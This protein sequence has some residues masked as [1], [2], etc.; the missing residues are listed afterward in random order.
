MASRAGCSSPPGASY[1]ATPWGARTGTTRRDA[2]RSAGSSTPRGASGWARPP[3]GA[4]YSPRARSPPPPPSSLP[5]RARAARREAGSGDYPP[6]GRARP[7]PRPTCMLYRERKRQTA[8]MA[9]GPLPTCFCFGATVAPRCLRLRIVHG[10][11]RRARV[12]L[13]WRLLLD[14]GLLLAGEV[15][16]QVAL[17]LGLQALH[18]QRHEGVQEE[19]VHHEDEAEGRVT[20]EELSH[21][22]RPDVQQLGRP[23]QALAHALVRRPDALDRGHHRPLRHV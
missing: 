7:W 22:H 8:Y 2:S 21:R 11:G 3:R 20:V 14:E 12:L 5:L 4:T 13:P 6:A 23:L 16:G 18:E 9:P 17:H 10:P 19:Q 15:V 1:A